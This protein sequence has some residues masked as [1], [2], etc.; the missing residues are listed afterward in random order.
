MKELS[1]AA[2][3]KFELVN[4]KTFLPAKED[5]P[6]NFQSKLRGF[7]ATSNAALYRA[8]NLLAGKDAITDNLAKK[9]PLSITK[10]TEGD[11]SRTIYIHEYV[12][13]AMSLNEGMTQSEALDM[14][15]REAAGGK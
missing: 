15:A 4:A 8:Q 12:D 11:E 2:V 5:S 13:A 1:G 7:Q 3:T 14:Y 6:S 9:Y 10:K